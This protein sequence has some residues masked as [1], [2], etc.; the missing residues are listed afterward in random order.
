MELLKRNKTGA[1]VFVLCQKGVKKVTGTYLFLFFGDYEE[2]ASSGNVFNLPWM[3]GT[4]G[5][6]DYIY[7]DLK[8]IIKC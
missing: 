1:N 3:S 7:V 5:I 4:N 6:L 8:F 2:G